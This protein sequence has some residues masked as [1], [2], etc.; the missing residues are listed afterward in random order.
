MPSPHRRCAERRSFLSS[1]STTSQPAALRHGL[2]AILNDVQ[3]RLF[4]QVGIDVGHQR[5]GRQRAVQRHIA[6]GELFGGQRQDVAD[7]RAQIL[8]AQLQ[9]HRAREIHQGLHDAVQAMNLRV[10]HL[11]VAGCR[12]VVVAQLVLQQFQVDHDGVDRVLHLVAH[13]GGESSDGGHAPRKLQLGLDF[14]NRLQV[15]QRDQSAQTLLVLVIVD[16]IQ[17][18][19]NAPA[20]FGA[21]LFLHHVDAGIEGLAQGFA[22]HGRAVENL[23]RVQA[24]NAVSVRR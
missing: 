10:D 11:K 2:R 23:P 21:D 3:H 24:Q 15:V 4:Q 9:F 20:R 1:S 7:H 12:R 16:E 22:Q 5:I 14:F 19:L 17:R 6:G 18:G 8:F 13:A